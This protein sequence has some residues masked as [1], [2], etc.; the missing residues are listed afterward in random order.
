M[1]ASSL[2]AACLGLCPLVALAAPDEQAVKKELW[3]ANSKLPGYVATY[4][5]KKEDTSLEATLARDRATGRFA[6]HLK[7]TAGG[8]DDELRQWSPDGD[9]M[10]FETD[11]QRFR[12][13]GMLPEIEFMR[14]L[15]KLS[16]EKEGT[17]PSTIQIDSI[18]LLSTDGIFVNT[19]M[20]SNESLPW[21]WASPGLQLGE[22]TES[23]AV[24]TSPERG[25]LEIDR[26][27]GLPLRQEVVSKSGK[28]RVLTR[29]QFRTTGVAEEITRL[30]ADWSTLGA[31]DRG[32]DPDHLDFRWKMFQELAGRVGSGEVSLETLEE[33]MA[34]RARMLDYGRK[35]LTKRTP[36]I[37]LP[38]NWEK[39]MSRLRD[40]GRKQ[41]RIAEPDSAPDDEK[42]FA[43][44]L[45]R[46]EFRA[47]LRDTMTESILVLDGAQTR[48][49]LEIFGPKHPG[50]LEVKSQAAKRAIESGLA[51]ALLGAV[52]EEKMATAWGER[53]GLE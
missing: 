51:R 22:V 23:Y 35:V 12:V 16:L 1:R 41:W 26:S 36:P 37:E 20:A 39:L 4:E 27:N 15:D 6:L 32:L 31:K 46:P 50:G 7:I 25:R 24:F 52:I 45:T 29:T 34:D 53:E 8:K 43:K 48:L 3:A 18:L 28:N 38:Y 47:P 13:V 19:V 33:T 42:A 10:F 30:S 11:G 49:L 40:E 5:A 44:Y 2:L 17:A 14:E 9:H 21:D